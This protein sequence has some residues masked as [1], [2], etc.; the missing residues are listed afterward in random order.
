MGA[1]LDSLDGF[2]AVTS[3]GRTTGAAPTLRLQCDA[4]EAPVTTQ[5]NPLNK[6]AS[7]NVDADMAALEKLM[8]E[9]R[10]RVL[11]AIDAEAELLKQKMQKLAHRRAAVLGIE[12]V[13][14]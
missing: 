1:T 11:G 13:G 7:V 5:A 12:R 8:R 4:E 3:S 14:A 9:R 6:P 2:P 10:K